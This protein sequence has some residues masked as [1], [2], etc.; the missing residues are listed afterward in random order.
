V[1]YNTKTETRTERSITY[2]MRVSRVRGCVDINVS[3]RHEMENER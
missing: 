3:V 2:N 1:G